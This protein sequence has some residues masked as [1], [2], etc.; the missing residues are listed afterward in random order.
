MRP[1]QRIGFQMKLVEEARG[2][3]AGMMIALRTKGTSIEQLKKGI[4]PM[5]W[6]VTTGLDGD[7][8][9]RNCYSVVCVAD[10]IKVPRFVRNYLLKKVYE[11][12][13]IKH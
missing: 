6:K 7:D 10:A 2:R 9:I 8:F 13:H 3:D 5:N 11:V 1:R 4:R 12:R